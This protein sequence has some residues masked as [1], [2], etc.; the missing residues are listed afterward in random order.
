MKHL[1]AQT[2]SPGSRSRKTP[3]SIR[4]SSTSSSVATLKRARKR[5]MSSRITYGVS[6]SSGSIELQSLILIGNCLF[7]PT[8]FT[9][10]WFSF[11]F[12]GEHFLLWP[13]GR[14]ASFLG[15]RRGFHNTSEVLFRL[16]ANNSATR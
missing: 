6:S 11:E 1:P 14:Q 7:D 16:R 4:M 3:Y 5:A 12:I 13:D 2:Q 10:N 8:R 15:R 9:E